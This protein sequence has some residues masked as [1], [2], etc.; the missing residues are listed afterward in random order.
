MVLKA[1]RN[2]LIQIKIIAVVPVTLVIV[3]LVQAS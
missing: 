3:L 1:V 2:L